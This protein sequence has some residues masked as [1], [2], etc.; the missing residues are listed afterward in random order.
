MRELQTAGKPLHTKREEPMTAE[1]R[2]E[3]SGGVY[4]QMFMYLILGVGLVG[5]P[6]LAKEDE[7]NMFQKY[8]ISSLIFL[9]YGTLIVMVYKKMQAAYNGTKDVVMGF[10]TEKSREQLKKGGVCCFLTIGVDFPVQV[11]LSVYRQYEV[12]DAIEVHEFSNWGHV[13]LSHKR[14]EISESNIPGA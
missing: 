2:K 8:L 13:L 1:E 10:V 4:Y 9:G 11:E 7:L 3:V 6:F 5:F 14:L 12:G